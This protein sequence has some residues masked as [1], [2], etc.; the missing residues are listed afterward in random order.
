MPQERQGLTPV[1]GHS[2]WDRNYICPLIIMEDERSFLCL[3]GERDLVRLARMP[4]E[5]GVMTWRCPR[6]C[7]GL[8]LRCCGCSFRRSDLVRD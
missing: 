3:Y 5:G 6:G 8:V 7:T 4:V 1:Y 2:R